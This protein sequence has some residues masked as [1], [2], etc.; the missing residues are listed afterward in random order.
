MTTQ[1][2]NP[3]MRAVKLPGRVLNLPSLGA[4]YTQ[5][6]LGRPNGEVHVQAMSA[7]DEITLK[8]PDLL[9]NGEALDQIVRTCAPD[10]LKPTE[11]YGRDIDA[12]MLFLRV[13]TYGPEFVIRV[14]HDCDE[15]KLPLKNGETEH[16]HKEHEYV[17]NL[18]QMIMNMKTLDPTDAATRYKV[19]LDN[20]QTVTVAPVRYKDLIT[21]FQ[22]TLRNKDS[23]TTEDVKESMISNLVMV[24]D[25]VDGVSDKAQIEEW[26]RVLTTRQTKAIAAA[27]EN[28]SDWGP[29]ST[30][31]C[32][33]RDCGKPFVAELPLN[34]ISFFTE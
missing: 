30:T 13:V 18:E 22:A 15:S 19:T 31:T 4:L 24:V 28:T 23:F 11:L 14:Q 34:P 12:L 5:G 9:F 10:I 21:L 32:V 33:C 3:L 27:V 17:V 20:G 25:N 7:L 2:L 26:A 8:N 16:R 29:E 1:A 6:E